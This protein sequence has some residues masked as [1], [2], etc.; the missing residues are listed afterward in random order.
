MLKLFCDLQVEVCRSGDLTSVM[1]ESSAPSTV[2]KEQN[3]VEF[4][5]LTK[6]KLM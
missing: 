4:H 3:T 1:C 5:I 2:A 6:S